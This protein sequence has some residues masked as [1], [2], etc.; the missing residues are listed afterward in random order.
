MLDCRDMKP[1]LN[2]DD[3]LLRAVMHATGERKKSPTVVSAVSLLINQAM[4]QRSR[5]NLPN[6]DFFTSSFPLK[7]MEAVNR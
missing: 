6:A 3:H 1:T 7:E 5:Q 4:D 2:I